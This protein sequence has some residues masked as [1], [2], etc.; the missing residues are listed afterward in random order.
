MYTYLLFLRFLIFGMVYIV[1]YLLVNMLIIFN[2]S[3]YRKKREEY[4]SK[5][6]YIVEPLMYI[7]FYSTNKEMFTMYKKYH[8]H[9]FCL[10]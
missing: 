8:W 5:D 7:L 9:S 1:K 4:V 10:Y 2:K 3:F 6:L